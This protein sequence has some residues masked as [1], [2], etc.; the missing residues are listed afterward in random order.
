LL[1]SIIPDLTFVTLHIL[2]HTTTVLYVC[3]KPMRAV[4]KKRV[5]REGFASWRLLIGPA[6]SHLCVFP[7]PERYLT[8]VRARH[9]PP[10]PAM[11]SFFPTTRCYG[12]CALP[13]PHP[14]SRPVHPLGCQ[15]TFHPP[16]PPSRH[17]FSSRPTNSLFQGSTLRI[18]QYIHFCIT[19][20][21]L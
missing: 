17:S 14:P 12:Y 4:A 8:L 15:L 21:S 18:C 3:S 1:K 16:F 2:L 10:P 11:S 13:C 9:Q 5:L 19:P 6:P 7:V 20:H